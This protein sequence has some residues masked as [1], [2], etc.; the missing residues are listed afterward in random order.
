[1]K[2]NGGANADGEET[3]SKINILSYYKSGDNNEFILHY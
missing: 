1:M 2:E 3:L